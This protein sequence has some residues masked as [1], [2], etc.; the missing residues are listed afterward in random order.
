MKKIKRGDKI[1]IGKQDFSS[2]RSSECQSK[3][4]VREMFEV[5]LIKFL[6]LTIFSSLLLKFLHHMIRNII[7][8]LIYV[9]SGKQSLKWLIDQK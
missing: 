8:S 4:P 9:A 7:G 6:I 1:F 3:S 5:M 2:F